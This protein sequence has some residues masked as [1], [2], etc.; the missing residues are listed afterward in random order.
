MSE[1]F[2]FN[3]DGPTYQPRGGMRPRA[4]GLLG[5]VTTGAAMVAIVIWSLLALFAFVIADPVLAWLSSA[6]G[7]VVANGESAAKMV[8]GEGLGAVLM[9]GVDAQ[10]LAQLV[11]DLVTLLAKP[12][13]VIIWAVG[14]AILLVLP[15]L[16]RKIS[17]RFGI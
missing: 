9:E 17:G 15:W 5:R 11:M 6:M 8:G 7:V 4:A 12:V 3:N 13:I 10:G 1:R 16:A 14:V 2:P